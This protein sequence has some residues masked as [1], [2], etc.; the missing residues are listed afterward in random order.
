MDPNAEQAI[1]AQTEAPASPG[2]FDDTTALTW[3][4]GFSGLAVILAFFIALFL[5]SRRPAPVFEDP[6]QVVVPEHHR[7]PPP[8]PI[9]GAADSQAG[10]GAPD[11]LAGLLRRALANSRDVLQSGFDAVFKSA[12]VDDA[13]FDELEEALLRAD[14][15]QRT[16]R[17]LLGP[18]REQSKAG[19]E[20]PD[21]LRKEL[22]QGIRS[23]L[24]AVQRPLARPDGANPWVILVVGVNG[25]G[26]TTTIGKLAAR[27]VRE[28]HKVMLG[29]GDT[30]RAAAVQQLREW[31]ERSGADIVAGDPGA[32]PGAVVHDTLQAA[33]ARGH[34][35]VLI[36]TAGR[37]QTALPLMEQLGKVR[38]VIDKVV[39]GAP[40]E[41]LMV[42]DGTMGQ[43]GLSQAT[44][45]NE[46]VPLSGVVVTKL[47]GTAKG[48]MLLTL[49]HELALPVPLIGLGEGVDDLRDFDAE[50]YV[51]ALG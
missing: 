9:E 39:P 16:A 2:F 13:A 41:T 22:R 43:N 18:L 4:G 34:D 29:A 30:Y 50:A 15:S 37:L 6:T 17:W 14:V 24:S 28:G 19:A 12:Q 1:Q 20:S 3:I 33:L 23:C 26:K 31:A 44:R 47:D 38:R 5:R 10:E 48:G 42:L 8:E 36:D 21:R 11:G 35:I 51:E 46:A 32:D 49:A 25:S 45:F 27:F 40:H 7:S